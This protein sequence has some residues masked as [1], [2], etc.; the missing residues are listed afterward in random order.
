MEKVQLALERFL[1]ELR[2]LQRKKIFSEVRFRLL[3]AFFYNFSI[4]F[5]SPQEEISEIV[6]KRRAFEVACSK[7]DVKPVDF[8][9]YLEYEVRLEKLRKLRAKRTRQSRTALRIASHS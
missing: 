6:T 1:P 2:D 3:S 5:L 8:L 4:S 7:R 9:R